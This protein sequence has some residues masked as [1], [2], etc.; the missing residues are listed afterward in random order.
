MIS[1][2]FYLEKCRIGSLPFL[3]P[4]SSTSPQNIEP[5]PWLFPESN[6]QP[7]NSEPASTCQGHETSS[8]S[9]EIFPQN[10]PAESLQ[11]CWR[12]LAVAATENILWKIVRLKYFHPPS[13]LK[14]LYLDSELCPVC[15]L[16]TGLD[17]PSRKVRIPKNFLTK[18]LMKDFLSL[19]LI[20]LNPRCSKNLFPCSHKEKHSPT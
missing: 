8:K 2:R 5:Q 16:Y 13:H 4:H 6:L 12:P 3:R 7:E 15:W 10:V 14:S 11:S 1:Q 19:T 18:Y 17:P 9:L 20:K